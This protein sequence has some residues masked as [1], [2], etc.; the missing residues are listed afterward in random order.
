M[1]N[2]KREPVA[3]DARL[4]KIVLTEN[5]RRL[6]TQV[7]HDIMLTEELLTKG[8]NEDDIQRLHQY[9]NTMLQNIVVNEGKRPL[10]LV[11]KITNKT[12]QKYTISE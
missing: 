6:H 12:W 10:Y 9:L 11:K 4:K 1:Y 8:L 5:A 3:H 2:I 7:K